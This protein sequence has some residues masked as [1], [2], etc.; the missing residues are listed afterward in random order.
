MTIITGSL[1][2]VNSVPT[3]GTVLLRA[4]DLRPGSTFAV[5]GEPKVAVITAGR[6][7]IEDVEPGPA[8]LTIQGNGA[9]H[10]VR[11]DVAD[12]KAD[13]AHPSSCSAPRKAEAIRPASD[14]KSVV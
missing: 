7:V 5:T 12:S 13:S 11:V 14:R 2:S 6:F 1:A 9:T 3:E 10:D 8:Q 4:L